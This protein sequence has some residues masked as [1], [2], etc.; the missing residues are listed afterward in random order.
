VYQAPPVAD[1]PHSARR[2]VFPAPAGAITVDTRRRTA[3]RN[4]VN[5]RGRARCGRGSSGG[6]RFPAKSG[7]SSDNDE[8]GDVS[9]DELAD[10]TVIV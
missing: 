10:L 3:R 4:T 2:I 5:K 7:F 9:D 1:R 6:R 8:R